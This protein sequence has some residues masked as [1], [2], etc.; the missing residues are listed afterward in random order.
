MLEE[1]MI[2]TVILFDHGLSGILK[3]IIKGFKD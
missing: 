3:D 1:D 2:C